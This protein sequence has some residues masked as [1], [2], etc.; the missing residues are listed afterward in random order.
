MDFA[1]PY[2]KRLF[3]LVRVRQCTTAQKTI[4]ESVG[5]WQQKVNSERTQQQNQQTPTPFNP[6]ER[7]RPPP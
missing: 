4:Q 3:F 2:R 1:L 6:T 5:S 7:Q